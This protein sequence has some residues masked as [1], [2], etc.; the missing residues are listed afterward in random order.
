M[1]K[2]RTG[3]WVASVVLL[4]AGFVLVSPALKASASDDNAAYVSQLLSQAKTQAFQLSEDAGEMAS[5]PYVSVPRDKHATTINRIKEDVNTMN[6]QLTKLEE[7]RSAA[8]PWQRTAID[9]IAPLLKEMTL[10]TTA[11]IEHLNKNQKERDLRADA[12]KDYLEANKDAS[13]HL[14]SLIS[15]FVDYGKTK[16]RLENLTHRLELEPPTE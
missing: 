4:A 12:Y 3:I 8:L 6:R 14:S 9:R 10:N 13:S 15:D 11:A 16:E 1:T 2:Y 7:A 5:F